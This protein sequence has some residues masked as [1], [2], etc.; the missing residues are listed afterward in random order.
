MKKF[1]KAIWNH[2]IWIFYFLLTNRDRLRYY[3]G[4]RRGLHCTDIKTALT[5]SEMTYE[6]RKP[7][8]D[9]MTYKEFM[10]LWAN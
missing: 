3:Y 10:E 1:F 8:R 7:E 6:R 9:Y 2:I 5:Y 4:C